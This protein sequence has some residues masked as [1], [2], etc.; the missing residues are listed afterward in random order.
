MSKIY[1]IPVA[2]RI[3]G[4]LPGVR[5]AGDSPL[6]INTLYASFR[7]T[8]AELGIGSDN[9]VSEDGAAAFVV[10]YSGQCI[11]LRDGHL[12]VEDQQ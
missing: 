3:Q 2:T 1:G 10:G 7:P 6:E 9:T 8:T 4:W 11:Y 5:L 12:I